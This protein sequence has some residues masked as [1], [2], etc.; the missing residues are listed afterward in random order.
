MDTYLYSDGGLVNRNPS[1][2]G[3]TW[4]WVRVCDCK[5]VKKA[6]GVVTPKQ[7]NRK[8]VTNNLSE[9]LAAVLAVEDML[10][11]NPYWEGILYTDSKITQARL[12]FS[13]KFANIPGQLKD[14]TIKIRPALK[15]VILLSGHPTLNELFDGYSKRGYPVSRYNKMCDDMCQDEAKKFMEAYNKD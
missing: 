5:V 6:S 9:L 4:A 12:T 14:R 3:G 2:Y 11:D 13:K 1:T 15:K 8:T 10:L 7:I